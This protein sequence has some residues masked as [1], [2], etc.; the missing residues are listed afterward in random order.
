MAAAI[1]MAV[2]KVSLELWKRKGRLEW[3]WHLLCV[4]SKITYS[5]FALGI[6]GHFNTHVYSKNGG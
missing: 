6:L 4:Q 3:E 5:F 1:C 2:G